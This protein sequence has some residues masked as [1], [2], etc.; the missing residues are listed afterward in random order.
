MIIPRVAFHGVDGASQVHLTSLAHRFD[1]SW[2]SLSRQALDSA[3][4]HMWI[5]S[6]ESGQPPEQKCGSLSVSVVVLCTSSHTGSSGQ[7][8]YIVTE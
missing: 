2:L 4:E 3:Y 1:Q 8:A 5:L 6:S 7:T